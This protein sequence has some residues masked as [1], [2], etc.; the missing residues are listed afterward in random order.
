VVLLRAVSACP[1][2]KWLFLE[3]VHE[4][5][6]ELSW[7]EVAQLLSAMLERGAALMT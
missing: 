2:N 6:G 5:A 3:R 1:G 4:L 7:A